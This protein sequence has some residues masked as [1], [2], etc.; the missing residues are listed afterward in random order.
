M[1]KKYDIVIYGA[2]SFVG[3]IT[4]EY[5][6][7]QYGVNNPYISWAIAAR[8]ETKLEQL[9][10]ALNDA[11]IPTIIANSDDPDSLKAMCAQTKLVI[12]TVGPYAFYGESLVKVCAETGTHYCD[13]T[14]EPLWI[15]DMIE[16]YESAA[17]ASGAKIVNC[18]GFDSIPSDLGTFYLQQQAQ[19][20]F[21][22]PCNTVELGVKAIKGA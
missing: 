19:Q 3:E 21:S 10:K 6:A 8:S 15:A 12:S 18:C 1:D 16:K 7:R 14:G 4:V 17:K 20:E 2:T 13:L 5:F 11:S 22:A 9:N